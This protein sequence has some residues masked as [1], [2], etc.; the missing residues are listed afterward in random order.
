MPPAGVCCVST[1]PPPP[2]KL[3]PITYL[4]FQSRY[5]APPTAIKMAKN[6]LTEAMAITTI[7]VSIPAATLSLLEA[8]ATLGGPAW[9]PAP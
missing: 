5:A 2:K 6:P 3:A 7:R 8:L 1:S 9:R 4:S